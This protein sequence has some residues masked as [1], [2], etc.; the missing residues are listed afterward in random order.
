LKITQDDKEL[1]LIEIRYSR[2]IR[3]IMV[4]KKIK[5]QT[6]FSAG[7]YFMEIHVKKLWDKNKN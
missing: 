6:P 7:F 3:V 2:K 1:L 4:I 5:V